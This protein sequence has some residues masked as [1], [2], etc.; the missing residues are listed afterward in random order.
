MQDIFCSSSH[1]SQRTDFLAESLGVFLRELPEKIGISER[2]LFGYRSGKYP[3]TAKALRKLQA[4]ERAAGIGNPAIPN[5]ESEAKVNDCLRDYGEKD[6]A[7]R[8]QRL[9][10]LL[11]DL[12]ETITRHLK[13]RNEP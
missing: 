5:A 2:S 10:N 6:L 9:E 11:T 3:V 13:E 7:A 12:A 1:F 4:A 8:V